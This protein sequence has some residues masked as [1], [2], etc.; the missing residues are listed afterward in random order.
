M[1]YMVDIHA[2]TSIYMVLLQAFIVLICYPCSMAAQLVQLKPGWLQILAVFFFMQFPYILVG[3]FLGYA[4]LFI[5][6]F[7]YTN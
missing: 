2:A 3:S 5:Y 1:I 4:I 6:N 7:G